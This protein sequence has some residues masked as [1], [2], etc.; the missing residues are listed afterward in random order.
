MAGPQ[1]VRQIN[2][3]NIID[4]DIGGEDFDPGNIKDMFRKGSNNTWL[5]ILIIV[6]VVFW[7]VYKRTR[8]QR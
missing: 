2:R 6:L 5:I 8:I 4:I 7:F 1:K 3:R